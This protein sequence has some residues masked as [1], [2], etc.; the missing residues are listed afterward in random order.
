MREGSKD[1]TRSP[2]IDTALLNA[3]FLKRYIIN[4]LEK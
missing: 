2:S 4:Q 3:F 1:N